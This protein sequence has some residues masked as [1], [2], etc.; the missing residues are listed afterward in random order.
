MA[1]LVKKAEEASGAR[2]VAVIDIGASAMRLEVAEI[3][4]S[5]E[6][7]SLEALQRP[8][9]LGKDTFAAGCIARATIEECAEIGRGFRRVLRD[10][11]VDQEDAIRAV[12]TS[13]VREAVNRESFL[14]RMYVAAGLEVE[15]IDEAEVNR[16]TYIA[17]RANLERQQSRLSACDTLIVEVGGGSTEVLLVQEGHV[18]LSRTYRLG[19][20]RM[21][22]MLETHQTA[23]RRMAD[24][25]MRYIQRTSDQIK[26]VI[27]P[28]PVQ[29]L[30]IL[31]GDARFAADILTPQ[32]Q[33]ARLVPVAASR[34]SRFA[35]QVAG[36]RVEELVTKYQLPFQEAETAGPALLAYAH[37]GQAFA[38]DEILIS[39]I[40]LR[41]GMLLEMANRGMWTAHFREQVLYSARQL[42]RKYA[43]EEPHALHVAD[44]CG[45]LFKELQPEHEL[46]PHYEGLLRVAALLHE[47]GLYIDNQ[48]HHKHSQYLIENSDLFGLTRKDTQRVALIA[49]YHRR[50][51]PR[52]TH[53]GYAELSRADRLVIAKLAAILRVADALDQN[54]MQQVRD[55]TFTRQRGQLVIRVAGV[56][57]LTLERVAMQQK[58]LLFAETYGLEIELRRSTGR[59]GMVHGH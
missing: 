13:S 11:G 31:G 10:Y 28:E 57:D 36:T 45:R 8:V 51:L 50:A 17:V 46:E 20:L 55:L 52:A 26:R 39:R 18:T 23:P 30:I 54:H 37:L 7:R 49:R 12:A 32:Q 34:L 48:G 33:E 14:N 25:L 40:T 43:Y 59:G 24:I 56:E 42:G 19:A 1:A 22:E 9:N 3:N 15:P 44:L 47:I 35:R 53:P 27:P 2:V 16:L 4:A 38:V 21:R 41:D 58:G 5:G 6:V 29:R